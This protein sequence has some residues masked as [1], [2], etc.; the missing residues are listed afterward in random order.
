[1]RL[2]PLSLALG[3]STLSRTTSMSVA[4]LAIWPIAASRLRVD[5][6]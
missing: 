5:V 2:V 3:S 1:L 4:P 6:S